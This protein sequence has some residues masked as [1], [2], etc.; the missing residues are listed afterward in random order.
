MEA[1]RKRN[2]NISLDDETSLGSFERN[3]QEQA[4]GIDEVATRLESLSPMPTTT[5]MQDLKE[6]PALWYKLHVLI[7]DLRSHKANS[8]SRDRLETVI[9][10]SYVGSPYFTPAEATMVKSLQVSR[11]QGSA[12]LA[13]FIEETLKERLERRMKKR[14]ESEDYRV[15]AAHDIAPILERVMSVNEKTLMKERSFCY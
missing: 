6:L 13:D 12:T 7:F 4:P 8:T 2:L 11:S 14:E 9:D 15:C 10:P 1:Q 5:S 3:Y